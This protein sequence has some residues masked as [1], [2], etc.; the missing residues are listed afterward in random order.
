MYGHRVDRRVED[1]RER[2]AG[3]RGRENKRV[4]GEVKG[5]ERSGAQQLGI[6][7]DSVTTSGSGWCSTR[8]ISG[9][10]PLC[11][12]RTDDP[13]RTQ[14]DTTSP[15][16]DDFC[17]PEGALDL[18]RNGGRSNDGNRETTFFLFPCFQV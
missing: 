13:G 6:E 12:G 4:E 11:V 15:D 3:G 2:A 10:W 17:G 14:D 16:A 8:G 18:Y 9:G 1:R 5:A 7:T